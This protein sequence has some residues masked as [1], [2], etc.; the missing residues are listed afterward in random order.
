M[1]APRILFIPAYGVCATFLATLFW[2][3]NSGYLFTEGSVVKDQ[4]WT[5]V[6]VIEWDAKTKWK[7][8]IQIIS[9]VWFNTFLVHLTQM[10][11]AAAASFW[12]FN[13]ANDI[14]GRWTV[15]EGIATVFVYHLGSVAFGSAIILPC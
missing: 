8:A 5:D 12:Y 10:C 15:I 11:V 4:E 13:Q 3:I 2:L 1:Q 9:F 6:Y 14:K 7:I